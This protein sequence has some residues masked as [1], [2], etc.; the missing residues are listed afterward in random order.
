MEQCDEPGADEHKGLTTLEMQRWW[1]WYERTAVLQQK[2]A[3]K[4][5]SSLVSATFMKAA[6]Q[7]Q[8]PQ[9]WI[10]SRLTECFG[11]VFLF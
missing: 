10:R 8:H 6:Y 2:V 4:E 9:E 1:L 5:N 3:S 7:T 11:R